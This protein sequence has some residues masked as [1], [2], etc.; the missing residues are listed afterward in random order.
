MGSSKTGHIMTLANSIIGVGIL[1]MP[2][3]FQKVIFLKSSTGQLKKCLILQCGIILAIL[4]LVISNFITRLCCYYL[5]KSSL[6]CRRRS[7]E[8]IAFYVF[9]SSGKLMVELCIIGYLMGACITY[10]VVVG[11]LGPQI[12]AKMFDLNQTKTL[13]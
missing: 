12:T 6:T 2:F 3:C 13:R 4:L 9:G 10:Y 7:M 5:L 11:D 8:I 1:A